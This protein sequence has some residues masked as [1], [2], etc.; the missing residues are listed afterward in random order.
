M[1]VFAYARNLLDDFHLTYSFGTGLATAGDPRELGLGIEVRHL[2]ARF[3]A[4]S[5]LASFS[6]EPA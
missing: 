5:L 2:L 1:T 3:A 4:P 6:S